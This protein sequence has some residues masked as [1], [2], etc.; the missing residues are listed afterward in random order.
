MYTFEY[1]KKLDL[2]TL[3][4]IKFLFELH[5]DNSTQ[6]N[7]YRSLIQIIEQIEYLDEFEKDWY[8]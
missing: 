7:G 1:L 4:Q 6:T 8:R 3:K 2:N 5:S